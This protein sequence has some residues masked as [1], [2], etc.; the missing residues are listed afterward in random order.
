MWAFL[1]GLF[2][3]TVYGGMSLYDSATSRRSRRCGYVDVRDVS[4]WN[5]TLLLR[6]GWEYNKYLE[7]AYMAEAYYDTKR[8]Y[9]Q[10]EQLKKQDMM[11]YPEWF[12][13]E[14]VTEEE[15]FNWAFN[16]KLRRNKVYGE[17]IDRFLFG[18]WNNKKY[19]PSPRY[20]ETAIMPIR[21]V[22]NENEKELI[23]DSQWVSLSY[24]EEIFRKRKEG[25]RRLE[26]RRRL[27]EE[28]R[29]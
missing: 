19:L 5:W 14:D 29:L 9:P 1:A 13:D 21:R 27:K 17:I 23:D 2:G 3:L 20:T 16:T 28:G 25:E 15:F 8:L 4:R 12:Y 10:R 7:K 11:A 18:P 6:E 22:A 24:G 26:E